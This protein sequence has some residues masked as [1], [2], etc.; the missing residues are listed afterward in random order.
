MLVL[1]KVLSV[2]IIVQVRD[3]SITAVGKET[4]TSITLFLYKI[5]KLLAGGD[6]YI[7]GPYAVKF[8]AGV[9]VVSFNI[10]IIDDYTV[11]V[12]ENFTLSIVPSILRVGKPSQAVVTII[13]DDSKWLL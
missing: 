11:E 13:E 8:S 9:T 3:I 5:S 1:N 7:S 10:S 2:D 6:D 4:T 12:N